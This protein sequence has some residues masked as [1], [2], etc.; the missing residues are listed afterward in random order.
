MENFT[1][2]KELTL[3]ENWKTFHKEFEA[4]LE[5]DTQKYRDFQRIF[6]AGMLTG[7][8]IFDT[9]S[10]DTTFPLSQIIAFNSQE[11]LE[12]IEEEMRKTKL[13]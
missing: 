6:Y 10:K 5:E 12:F 13:S 8:K 9:V 11:F 1:L 4:D 2:P 3:K 7:T